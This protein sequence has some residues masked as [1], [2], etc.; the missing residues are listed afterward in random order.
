MH[1]SSIMA[2]FDPIVIVDDDP[3]DRFLINEILHKIE[4][5]NPLIFFSDGAEALGY[6]T[7]ANVRTFLILCDVN[8]PVMDGLQLQKAIDEDPGLKKK[9]I[10]FIFLSTTAT[11]V[12]VN[13]AYGNAVQGFFEKGKNLEELEGRLRLIIEYWRECKHPSSFDDVV[14]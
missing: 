10:P 4:V 14:L 12:E 9:S 11:P 5:K 8:M 13:E 1:E 7:Q 3:D 2:K 6:L